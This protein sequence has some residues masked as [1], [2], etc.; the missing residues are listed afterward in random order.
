MHG[1]I[2]KLASLWWNEVSSNITL[3][4][5]PSDN[6]HYLFAELPY[7]AI[8]RLFEFLLQR[9]GC[10]CACTTKRS[11]DERLRQHS[12]FERSNDA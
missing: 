5:Q 10:R 6:K 7:L 3:D 11:A 4:M 1:S 12:R 8:S 9:L 2:Q